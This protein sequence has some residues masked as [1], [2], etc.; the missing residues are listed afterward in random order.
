MEVISPDSAIYDRNTKADIYAA[1]GI[2]ELWLIDETAQT[3]ELRVLRE[4]RYQPGA[5]LANDDEVRST[6]LQGFG[7]VVRQVFVD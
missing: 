1:L 2:K 3:V 6:I 5:L 4:D 7:F